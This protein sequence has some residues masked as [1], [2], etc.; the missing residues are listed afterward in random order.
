MK[1]VLLVFSICMLVFS[2]QWQKKAPL[3]SVPKNIDPVYMMDVTKLPEFNA[4]IILSSNREV[5]F[6]CPKSMFD[7]YLRPYNYPEYKIKKESDFKKL[8]V[9][10]YLS[11]KWIDAKSALY[12]F[13]SRVRSPKGDDLIPVKNKDV[14][15]IYMLKYGGSKVL[16]FTDIK[17][18]GMGLI[19]YLDMP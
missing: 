12:V 7:F 1:K 18:K 10:D 4:K 15:N 2:S 14:L 11:G 16:S 19:K 9:K 8:L 3:K 5:N 6:C 13:G 17:Q